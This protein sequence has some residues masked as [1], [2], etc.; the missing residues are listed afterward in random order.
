M[1][2]YGLCL[3]L[4]W[5]IS[6]SIMLSVPSM[7]SQRQEGIMREKGE[8]FTGTIIKDIWTTTRGRGRW[9]GLQ[10]WGGVGDGWGK[11]AENCT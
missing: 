2:S 5:L 11:K 7:P 1:R 9:G 6:L 3:S 8:G 10:W 4:A